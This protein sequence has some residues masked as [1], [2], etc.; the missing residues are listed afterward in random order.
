MDESIL[1]TVKKLLGIVAEDDAFD[2]DMIVL[3]N[4]AILA[5]YEIGGCEKVILVTSDEE[6]WESLVIKEDIL[7]AAQ[8]YVAIKV[9]LGFDIPTSSNVTSALEKTM[10]EAEWRLNVAV[11]PES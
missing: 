4:N 1:K 8:T 6:T 5:L 9:R 7:G 10:R 2:T 3:I 11:D